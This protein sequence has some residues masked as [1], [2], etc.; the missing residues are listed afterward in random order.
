MELFGNVGP[1]VLPEADVAEHKLAEEAHKAAKEKYDQE[2][3]TYK[4]DYEIYEKKKE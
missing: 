3:L 2:M 4:F 1:F